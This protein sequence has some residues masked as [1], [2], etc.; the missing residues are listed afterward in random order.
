MKLKPLDEFLYTSCKG[1]KFAVYDE[2]TQTGCRADQIKRFG[3]ENIIEAYDNES[4]FYVI[5]TICPYMV[6]ADLNCTLEEAREHATV[7]TFGIALPLT[8]IEQNSEEI[9]KTIRSICY[10][11]YRKEDFK[12]SISHKYNIN[13][14]EKDIV[15]DQI[16]ILDKEGVK[17]NITVYAS[18]EFEEKETFKSLKY[19]NYVTKI[20]VG[21][22]LNKNRLREI[23]SIVGSRA[24]R[25]IF[26]ES[27]EANFV[28]FRSISSRYYEYGANYDETELGISQEL[29]GDDLYIGL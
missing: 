13:N 11:D 15:K 18:S 5:K 8:G 2:K 4:E 14:D 21:N 17:S 22:E 7:V 23:E 1:C 20:K 10:V 26:F 6:P 3:K 9:S 19:A 16:S 27:P 28:L 24:R 29:S 25:P 12:L